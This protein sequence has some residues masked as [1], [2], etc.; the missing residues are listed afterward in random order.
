[1][2][3]RYKVRLFIDNTYEVILIDESDDDDAQDIS[4]FQGS[5]SDCE[6]WIRL[7]EGGYL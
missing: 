2:N 4:M 3:R 7:K 6:A 5:L 1:M